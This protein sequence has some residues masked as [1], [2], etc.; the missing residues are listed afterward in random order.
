MQREGSSPGGR[1]WTGDQL[2]VDDHTGSLNIHDLHV[3]ILNL[4]SKMTKKKS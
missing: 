3:K 1:M 2:N 4:R